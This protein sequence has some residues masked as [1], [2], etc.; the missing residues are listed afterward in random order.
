MKGF[1]WQLGDPCWRISANEGSAR[2]D[3]HRV[4][5]FALQRER[6]PQAGSLETPEQVF[7]ANPAR[8]DRGIG[9][10]KIGTTSIGSVLEERL[11][12][13]R[14]TLSDTP[15]EEYKT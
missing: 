7:F 5:I 3:R 1:A 12:V 11:I 14:F 13:A 10:M 6:P 2:Q 4:G 15:A 9:E 8:M